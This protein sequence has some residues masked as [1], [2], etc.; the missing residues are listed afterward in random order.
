MH[1]EQVLKVT[2]SSEI[3]VAIYCN[4]SYVLLFGKKQ[5]QNFEISLE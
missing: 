3:Y 4:G 5:Q 2:S 1:I